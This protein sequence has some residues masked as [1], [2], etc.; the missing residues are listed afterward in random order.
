MDSTQKQYQ[1][2]AKGILRAEI[3]RRNLGYDDL[4]EKLAALGAKENSP[5]LIQ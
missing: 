5:Q 1:E 2:K 3:K 4:A